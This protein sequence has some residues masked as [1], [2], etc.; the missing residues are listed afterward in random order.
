MS[1]NKKEKEA[2]FPLGSASSLIDADGL[3]SLKASRA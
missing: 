1:L 2:P 3:R